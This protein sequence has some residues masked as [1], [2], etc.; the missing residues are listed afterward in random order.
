[1]CSFS[2]ISPFWQSAG[3]TVM[4]KAVGSVCN[5]ACS[6]CYYLPKAQLFPESN[7]RMSEDLLEEFTQQYIA[8]QHVPEVTFIWQGGEPTIYGIDFYQKA[9]D[10]QRKYARTGLQIRNSLQTNGT[11]LTKEWAQF[12]KQHHFLV[13]ISID[14]SEDI[15][16]HFRRYPDGRPSYTDVIR[17]LHL[18]QDFEVDFNVLTCVNS[19]NANRGLEI[20][21]HFRDALE[22]EYLQFIP[23]V[24]R[25]NPTG[26]QQGGKLTSRS[27]TPRQ[28]ADFLI[29]IYDEWI[30]T[31]V[32]KVFVQLFDT[33][34]ASWVGE[35]AG[36]CV[37]EPTCGLGMVL[38]HNGNLYSCDHFV[39][40]DHLLGNLHESR[41]IDLVYSQQQHDFGI[42]KHASL[43]AYCRR[44]P[45]LF[46]CHGGCPKNRIGKSPDGEPGH[47]YLCKAYEA[48][49]THVNPSMTVMA[50]LLREHRAPAEVMA[51]V[52]ANP[53]M[54]LPLH[55]QVQEG[56]Q[57]RQ[58]H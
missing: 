46:A 18:L 4:V 28:Y 6:H 39:E 27:C 17:G 14:G 23:I 11:L 55:Q 30:Q 50:S 21:H 12:F 33:T 16:N 1:M 54:Y 9:I 57:H 8:A 49:F 19:H 34:L 24:E 40:P 38:E 35:Q 37:F 7:F 42:G 10:Y 25:A 36:L 20:Y 22:I 53:Q 41:L 13:G 52:R 47:N 45:W 51:Q 56:K 3:F 2:E 58:R 44:C 29:S 43:T 5:L 48:F 31:D 15:H 26:F 32:G